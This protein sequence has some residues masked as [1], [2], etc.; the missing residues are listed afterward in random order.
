MVGGVFALGDRVVDAGS[1]LG[2]DPP[3]AGQQVARVIGRVSG[4]F[5]GLAGF[6]DEQVAGVLTRLRG[7]DH[8][9][10][11]AG[12]RADRQSGDEARATALVSHGTRLPRRLRRATGR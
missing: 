3:A 11:S 2:D 4:A 12:Q 5:A 10:R 9:Q 6:G 8:G 1:C 7:E